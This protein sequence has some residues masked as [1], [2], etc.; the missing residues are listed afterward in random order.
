MGIIGYGEI[1]RA[2]RQPAHALGMRI[3]AVRRRPE[4]CREDQ[5]MEHALPPADRLKMI[6][7]CDYV[8]LATPKTSATDKLIGPSMIAAM[9]TNAVLIYV[10]RGN[11]VDED[12]LAAALRGNR[13][14]GPLS[15]YSP[16]NHAERSSVLETRRRTALAALRRPYSSGCRRR[17]I[18]PH[19]F[20]PVRQGST[21][22]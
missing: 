17:A 1:G 14:V 13:L 12:A 19:E 3:L 15:T 10:G 22:C 8:V 5:I 6:A 16:P 4:L 20:R 11:A 9:K 7:E 21:Y 2:A 18:V